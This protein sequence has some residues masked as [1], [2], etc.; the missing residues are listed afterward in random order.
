MRMYSNL[1]AAIATSTLVF[2]AQ[3]QEARLTIPEPLAHE[4]QE[5][6]EALQGATKAGGKTGEAAKQAMNAL[7]PHFEK[8]E[9]FALPQL[10]ALDALTRKGATIGAELRKDL[11][12]RTD[13]LRAELPGMLEEH[14]KISAALR[15]MKQAADAENNKDISRLADQIIAHAG[16]EERVLYPA[17]LLVGEY[18]RVFGK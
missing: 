13:T 9:K 7:K 5:I 16:M 2:A 18:A 17:S 11:V 1:M 4:H 15:Q 12:E 6:Y 8:E 10:G 14:K 3:G